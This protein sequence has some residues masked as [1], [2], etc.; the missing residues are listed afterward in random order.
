MTLFTLRRCRCQAKDRVCVGKILD[1]G[2]LLGY[3]IKHGED[4]FK[5]ED[6]LGGRCRQRR[7]F[8]GAGTL[9]ATISFPQ[10]SE[11]EELINKVKED[12]QKRKAEKAKTPKKVPPKRVG[13]KKNYHK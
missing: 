7:E 11:A 3:R 9:T 8:D 13:M 6:F 5:E 4:F 2:K 12:T 1:G 10:T